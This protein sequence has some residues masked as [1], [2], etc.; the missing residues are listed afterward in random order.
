[1]C[2]AGKVSLRKGEKK[3]KQNHGKE[4]SG[5]TGGRGGGPVYKQRERGKKTGQHP[6]EEM[7]RSRFVRRERVEVEEDRRGAGLKKVKE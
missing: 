1:V 5:T 4:L 3:D 7:G 2:P 6:N